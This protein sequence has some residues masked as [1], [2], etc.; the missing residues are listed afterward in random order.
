M[1]LICPLCKKEFSY[2]KCFIDHTQSECS[3]VHDPSQVKGLEHE[4]H[5]LKNIIKEIE[6]S[7]QKWIRKYQRLQGR[8]INTLS[9][10]EH[11]HEN[12]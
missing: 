7:E 4:I 10:I 8:F 11:V 6:E 5:A 1:V 12:Y 9:Y 3:I 2:K